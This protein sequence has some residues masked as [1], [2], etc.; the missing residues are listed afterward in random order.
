ML[1]EKS[2]LPSLI[3]QAISQRTSVMSLDVPG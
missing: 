2:G 1:V 3:A